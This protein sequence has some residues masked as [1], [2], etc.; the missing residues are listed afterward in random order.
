MKWAFRILIATST[1]LVVGL[2]ILLVPPHLQT[3]GISPPLPTDDEL[4]A[5][6]TVEDGPTQIH[7]VR[8]S[9]QPRPE[10]NLGHSAVVIEWPDGKLF[11]IDAAMDREATLE[12]ARTIALVSP[13]KGPVQFH[14]TIADRLGEAAPQISG[15]G[16]THLHID[17]VQGIHDLCRVRGAGASVYRTRLQAQEHNLH[18]REGAALVEESCFER[19]TLNGEGLLPV[20]GFP[21]LGVVALA[22]H[23]PGSTLFAVAVD[24]KLWLMSGDISNQK[25]MLLSNTGKGFF[26][27]GLVVPENTQRT[28]ELRLW[29][30]RL[31]SRPDMEVIVSHDF[32]A[33]LASGLEDFNP[34]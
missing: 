23:T 18:T 32:A 10:F 11:V 27:S 30:A 22:G 29:L 19:I 3:R 16:F 20:E 5:L 4:Q 9:Q 33:A 2:A 25:S 28:E 7:I 21:G 6:L 15:L 13:P 14:G 24:G 31:D 34:R 17:H 26:Y 12:F 1:V 8:S